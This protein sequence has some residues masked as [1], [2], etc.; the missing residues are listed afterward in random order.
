MNF[1]EQ[2]IKQALI[3]KGVSAKKMCLDIGYSDVSLYKYYEN[4]VIRDKNKAKIM[5]YLD[6]K[7]DDFIQHKKQSEQKANLPMFQTSYNADFFDKLIQRI[8]VLT[9]ENFT[10]KTQLGKFSG[11]RLA[12]NTK[13]F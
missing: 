12:L 6:L 13:F 11:I 9:I 10:L 3:R 1:R 2:V 5:Q 4:G 7:E 8:E